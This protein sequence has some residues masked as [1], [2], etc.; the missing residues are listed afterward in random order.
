MKKL[1]RYKQEIQL[2]G[3][4]QKE[5]YC[6]VYLNSQHWSDLK[7]SKF[8]QVGRKCEV[9]GDDRQIEVH[10]ERYR[11]LYDVTPADLKVL[12]HTHHEA[13]HTKRL[14][15]IKKKKTKKKRSKPVRKPNEQVV[16]TAKLLH[17]AATLGH[18]FN[19]KQ[20]HVM[21]L[22]WPPKKGWLKNLVGKSIKTSQ[23]AKFINAGKKQKSNQLD[24]AKTRC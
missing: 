20:L 4:S 5:W 14:A 10:H 8:A 1:P 19:A 17:D 22:G 18:G 6:E 23:Y 9:C 2:S 16:L 21:G 24:P 3:L 15:S 7:L 11:H 13:I 12:C